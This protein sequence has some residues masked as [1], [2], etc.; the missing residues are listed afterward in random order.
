MTESIWSSHIS[1]NPDCT[2][3]FERYA[4][5]CSFCTKSTN[6]MYIFKDIIKMCNLCYESKKWC[7]EIE[8]IDRSN[9]TIEQKPHIWKCYG[10]CGKIMGGGD[11]WNLLPFDID[12][13]DTCCYEDKQNKILNIKMWKKLTLD[14]KNKLYTINRTYPVKVELNKQYQIIDYQIP[15]L[16][17]NEITMKRNETYIEL[18]DSIVNLDPSMTDNLLHWTLF[19]DFHK[20]EYYEAYLDFA[21]KCEFPYPVASVCCDDHGRISMDVV[22]QTFE[23]YLV[24]YNDWKLS[25]KN[26]TKEERDLIINE[27]KEDDDNTSICMKKAL[28]ISK[29]FSEYIRLERDLPFYYG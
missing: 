5:E 26:Y 17:Q 24:A 1:F 6:E 28:S 22:F 11:I 29:S 3:N 2:D 20:L 14:N 25:R 21:I 15:E 4:P 19:T 9:F 8:V 18:L 23:D 12:L 16:L 27:I 13:C 7:S 10:N